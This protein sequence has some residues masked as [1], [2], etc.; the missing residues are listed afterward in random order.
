MKPQ[1]VEY[2]KLFKKKKSNIEYPNILETKRV[3]PQTDN[4]YFFFN[5]ISVLIIIIIILFL[6]FRKGNKEKQKRLKNQ[7]IIQFFHDTNKFEK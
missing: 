1:L 4:I 2:N 5:I 7:K 3:S 6:Y